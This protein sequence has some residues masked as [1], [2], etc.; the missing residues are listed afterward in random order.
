MGSYNT[1]QHEH[2]FT[3]LSDIQ[4]SVERLYHNGQPLHQLDAAQ[5]T[6]YDPTNPTR[7]SIFVVNS[8]TFCQMRAKEIFEVF[9][10]RHIL[11][12]GVE[13]EEMAFDLKGLAT[14]GSVT[15]VRQ[16]QGKASIL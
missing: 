5:S 2:E 14:L 10:H 8:S 3:F 15:R 9:R 7:S 4:A 13:T 12:T 6:A 1:F 11:V 16:M